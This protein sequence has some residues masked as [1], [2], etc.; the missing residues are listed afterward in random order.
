MVSTIHQPPSNNDKQGTFGLK[1]QF[2]T[3][4]IKQLLAGEKIYPQYDK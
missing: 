1:F 3:V 4:L 2:F